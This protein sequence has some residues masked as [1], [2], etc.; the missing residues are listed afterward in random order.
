M[1]GFEW[2]VDGQRMIVDQ[3]VF[4]YMA[5]ECRRGSRS[6]AN[7]NTLCFVD[8]DQA[9]FFGS[10]RCGRRPDVEIR[11]YAAGADGFVLEG[12][13]NGFANLPGAPRHVRRFEASADA[14]LICDRIEGRPDRA[15]SIGFLLH[16]DAHVEAFGNEARITRNDSDIEMTSTLPISIEDAVWWPDMGNEWPTHR[17]RI[18]IERGVSATT[19]LLRVAN[20]RR[21]IG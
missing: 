17:L 11:L 1:R 18:W 8:A 19:T 4:E 7:H 5:G 3:G 15:C 10:F 16:P 21:R 12:A 6:A 2:S 9:D 13:H 20:G 14:I